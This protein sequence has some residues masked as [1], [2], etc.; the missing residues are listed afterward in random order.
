VK[1]SDLVETLAR[2]LP[3]GTIRFGCQVEEISL[4]VFTRYPVVSTSDGST[5]KAKVLLLTL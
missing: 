3:E 1:R 4:D 5:I 2:H